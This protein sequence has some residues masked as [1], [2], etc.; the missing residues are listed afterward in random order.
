MQF[1]A[2]GWGLITQAL[3]A[4]IE[5]SALKIAV[6]VGLV[7]GTT[8]ATTPIGSAISTTRVCGSS[9]RMPTVRSGRM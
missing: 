4:L 7:E 1:R 5:M 2:E 6:D 3:R 8:A 9:R